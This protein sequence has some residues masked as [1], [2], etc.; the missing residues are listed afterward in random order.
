MRSPHR[1]V[2]LCRF[3]RYGAFAMSL[4]PTELGQIAAELD[5]ALK[6]AAVQ[7][8]HAPTRE[9]VYLE[10][11]IPG[12]SVHVHLC[13]EAQMARLS[14]VQERPPNPATPPAWQSVLRRELIGAT[15]EDVEAVEAR[16]LGVLHFRAKGG[17]VR[18]LA[19]E[20]GQPPSI[21]LLGE[22]GRILALSVSARSGVRVGGR[23]E[24]PDETPVR[25]TGSRLAGDRVFLRLASAAEGLFAQVEVRR[26]LDA[27]KAPVLAALK[28]LERTQEKVRGDAA[29]GE[30]ALRLQAEGELLKGHLGQLRRGATSVTVEAW[31]EDGVARPVTIALDPRRTPFE[32]V[33]WRFHQA[34]RLLRGVTLARARLE[35]LEAEAEK[36]R[37]DL[38]RLEVAPPTPGP[39][40][41]VREPAGGPLPPYREYRA[42][43]DQRVWVG[44][45][46]AHNDTLTFHVA[47]PFHVWFHA[48]GV[49]GA[50]VVVP[51]EK[52]AA[53]SSEVLLDAAHLAL[54]HSD[55]KREPKGEVSYTAVKFV[56]RGTAP[57]AVT[58][59]REKT[60]NLR[61][62]PERLKRLLATE[63]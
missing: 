43:G 61:V 5:R 40:A 25:D 41:S 34:K 28:R 11:R 15:L 54:H 2:A 20:L 19:L 62:E 13:C 39:A 9:R 12:H 53:L 47:R 35:A 1:A 21:A 30:R 58:Y 44:R 17:G 59:T 4:R 57:G 63:R 31:G 48:R 33:E 10:L 23:W 29:R 37:Q 3:P 24:P 55:A 52:H 22:E 45:G 32:E 38:M 51:L 8:V 26:G 46:A 16:R 14:V 7:K 50:H 18:T 49:P 42:T 36:L 60:I 27:A 6:K 56:R